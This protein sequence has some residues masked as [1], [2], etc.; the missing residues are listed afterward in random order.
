MFGHLK[1]KEFMN[2]I[3]G[4][5]LPAARRNHLDSCA[6]CLA[7][8]RSTE[9]A[10][11]ILAALAK[12]DADIPE[13]DW[14]DFRMTVRTELLSRAIQRESAVRRWTG[15]PIRPS[16]AWGL[17]MA[18]LI[19]LGVGGFFWHIS[20]DTEPIVEVEYSPPSVQAPLVTIA[21]DSADIEAE[22]SAWTNNGVF[23]ELSKLDEPQGI[24]YIPK[25][26]LVA[27]AGLL[28]IVL[29]QFDSHPWIDELAILGDQRGAAPV[30]RRIETSLVVTQASGPAAC[31]TIDQ[32][33]GQPAGDGGT[34]R[35]LLKLID[36]SAA[37]VQRF[38]AIVIEKVQ[39]CRP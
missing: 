7:Q 18:L 6:A 12:D 22:M 19:C 4:A 36:D 11:S 30:R 3:E 29:N 35:V 8:L 14:N 20:N 10:N 34:P 2:A 1:A 28:E 16:M 13:P 26:D 37:V 38:D 5:D 39:A 15:W 27:I 24:V 23:E 33:R 21:A 31:P 25:A 32:T 17:S 9:A